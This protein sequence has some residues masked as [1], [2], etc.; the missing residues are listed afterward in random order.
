MSLNDYLVT[1]NDVSVVHT[2]K[3]KRQRE[4]RQREKRQVKTGGKKGKEG[5]IK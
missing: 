1:Y 2:R 3:E 5:E 4:K